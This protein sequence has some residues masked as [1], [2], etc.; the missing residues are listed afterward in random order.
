MPNGRRAP[1]T[2]RHTP[3][4]GAH[5]PDLFSRSWFRHETTK[6]RNGSVSR[7][8]AVSVAR[9]KPLC[10]L[11]TVVSVGDRCVSWCQS[12]VQRVS[13]LLTEL[14]QPTC[15]GRI[16]VGCTQ[17]RHPL[18]ASCVNTHRGVGMVGWE[19][20]CTA[21]KD[22]YQDSYDSYPGSYLDKTL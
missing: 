7:E 5:V 14:T 1:S 22:S 9:V 6:T 11:V 18:L 15:Q 16:C 12:N 21:A 19:L 4:C 20:C 3:V 17:R 8:T 13:L 10:Q 2:H